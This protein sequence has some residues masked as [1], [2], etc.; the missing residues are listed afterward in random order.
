[1]SGMFSFRINSEIV[2]ISE[3]RKDSLD[4]RSARSK[5]TNLHRT[6]QTLN[7]R[8]KTDMPRVGFEPMIPVLKLA[9]KFHALVRAAN[10]EEVLKAVLMKS[11]TFRIYCHAVQR[12][13]FYLILSSFLHDLFLD[14]ED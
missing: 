5:D 14:S 3:S 10:L 11:C 9:K 8:R 7:K 13:V 4:G 12:A 2:N 6:T 1:M